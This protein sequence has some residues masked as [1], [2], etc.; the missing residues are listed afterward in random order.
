MILQLFSTF[1]VI[2]VLIFVGMITRHIKILNEEF[3]PALSNLL[4][5]VTLPAL[6]L[7]SLLTQFTKEMFLDALTLVCFGVLSSFVGYFIGL[8]LL[9][10]STARRHLGDASKRTFLML[11][12][13]G[14]TS[15]LSIPI[16]FSLYGEEVVVKIILFD[17]G[18]SII[19]WTFGIKLISSG[20]KNR[21]GESTL[22]NILNPGICA[23]LLGIFMVMF[24]L[25][26]PSFFI[27]ACG[28]LGSAT[29]PMSLIATGALLYDTGFHRKIKWKTIALLSI[30]KLIFMPLFFIFIVLIFDFSLSLKKIII[31]ESAMPSMILSTVLAEKYGSDSNLA[32]SGVFWTT[33][34][35]ILTVP[36]FLSI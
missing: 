9:A 8:L 13:F 7:H 28:L 14:N 20:G 31:L 26:V 24:E 35:S 27:K 23:L 29:I 18:V 2:F 3:T 21:I 17:L 22:K 16:G 30:G 25:Q 33:L 4:I 1:F 36:L 5:L 19:I 10:L 34:L 11:C 32:A 6:I 15:F 12:A